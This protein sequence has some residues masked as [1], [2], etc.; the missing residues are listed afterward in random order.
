MFS[1]T[2]LGLFKSV[3]TAALITSTSSAL[4]AAGSGDVHIYLSRGYSSTTANTVFQDETGTDFSERWVAAGQNA[5]DDINKNAPTLFDADG[6]RQVGSSDASYVSDGS[7]YLHIGYY[8]NG[9]V[10]SGAVVQDL[11]LNSDLVLGRMA[12]EAQYTN[13]SVATAT[14]NMVQKITAGNTSNSIEI[15]YGGTFDTFFFRGNQACTM[16]L[17]ADI[18]TDIANNIG[19][20]FNVGENN[21]L[22]FGTS[23][24]NTK[25]TVRLNGAGTA[26]W[27]VATYNKNGSFIS[28]SDIIISGVAKESFRV[29]GSMTIYGD[30]TFDSTINKT[31]FYMVNDD[32]T[33]TANLNV[34]GDIFINNTAEGF[35]L[36]KSYK[37]EQVVNLSNITIDANYTKGTSTGVLGE[38]GNGC[39]VNY[40]GTIKNSSTKEVSINAGSMTN[41]GI[42]NFKGTESN[43]FR[44][45][46]LR[47][48][49]FNMMK[50]GSANAISMTVQG[51][52]LGMGGRAIINSFG[53]NQLDLSKAEIQ[54]WHPG[55]GNTVSGII[56]LN[57]KVDTKVYAFNS[58]ARQLHVDFG[59]TD[60]GMTQA[61]L[62]AQGITSGMINATGAGIA[63]TFYLEKV[64]YLS[65]VKTS[66]IF[67]RN[68]IVGED[69]IICGEQL[70]STSN[71]VKKSLYSRTELDGNIFRIEGYDDAD[72]YGVDYWLA[73]IDLGDGTWGYQIVPEPA[74]IAALIGLVSLAFAA[75][76][77]K[78]A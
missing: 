18:K 53:E 52:S 6:Y 72:K 11:V 74:T 1:T 20:V 51:S 23:D 70:S 34:L 58:G 12:I 24:E 25:R 37:P 39:V 69:V 46:G 55:D 57:G 67:F 8:N 49:I 5:I 71:S 65:D 77:R 38:I 26:N 40:N 16:I 54:L 66:Y 61:Q 17:D 43:E 75:W 63:Q 42:A 59:M 2:P 19:V 13:N 3:L 48:G 15:S 56:N 36:V 31:G 9:C 32:A 22:V 47:R 7:A 10:G 4:F 28:Y 14:P 29:A 41:R 30:L 68:Y 76:R 73:E 64:V 45:L 62:T 44:G 78:K 35:T 33:K 60:H 21:S 50:S 27:F